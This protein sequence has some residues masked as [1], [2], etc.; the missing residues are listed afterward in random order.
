MIKDSLLALNSND[1]ISDKT[2]F[3]TFEIRVLFTSET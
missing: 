1:K 3:R 2:A